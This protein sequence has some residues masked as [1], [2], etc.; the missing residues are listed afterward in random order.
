MTVM[1]MF[2]QGFENYALFQV[3]EKRRKFKYPVNIGDMQH[4]II[5]F[6]L[7]TKDIE[8]LQNLKEPK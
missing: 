1:C 2:L 3:G 6:T 8:E 5:F 7:E 4:V